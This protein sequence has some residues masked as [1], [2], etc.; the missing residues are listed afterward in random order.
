MPPQPVLVKGQSLRGEAGQQYTVT[1]KLGEGQFAE[2]WEVRQSGAGSDLRFAL[3]VEKVADRKSVVH[4]AKVLTKLPSK[5]DQAVKVIDTGYYGKNFFMVMELLGDSL[6]DVRKQ[7]AS[8]RVELPTVKAVGLSTLGAIEGLHVLGF[9]H[10][11]IKPANFVISPPN[12][13]AGRGKWVLIDFGLARKYVGEDGSHMPPRS[14]ASFRGSTTYASVHAHRNEDLSRRDDLWSW[15]YMLTELVEGCLLWRPDHGEADK[16]LV[17]AEKEKCLAQPELLAR[18]KLPDAL[19]QIHSHLK[20]LSFQ[21]TPDY[22]H[23]RACLQQLPDEQ[24]TLQLQHLIPQHV[25]HNGSLAAQ[26][27]AWDNSPLGQQ[28]P[29][30]PFID[31]GGLLMSPVDSQGAA[32]A[33]HKRPRVSSAGDQEAKRQRPEGGAARHSWSQQQQ[34]LSRPGSSSSPCDADDSRGDSRQGSQ[35]P[36]PGAAGRAQ[37]P[38]GSADAHKQ[39]QQQRVNGVTAEPLSASQQQQQ[40]LDASHPQSGGRASEISDLLVS[41][42]R[43]ASGDS[44]AATQ[45]AVAGLCALQPL[46]AVCAISMTLDRLV[47][48]SDVSAMPAVSQLL[49]DL[50]AFAASG[51]SEASKAAKQ[52]AAAGA[53]KAAARPGS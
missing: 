41:F 10:R 30:S 44:K 24:V 25:Q 19:L 20:G 8:G 2:V 27:Q 21:D 33:G 6:W 23:L 22:G 37:E 11:D 16:Q 51:A 49:L 39:Q 15:F 26:Q 29:A 36:H 5:C 32:A 42:D 1:R 12:A 40:Q 28:L 50:A 13:A 46:H 38:L 52:Q 4:E 35:G 7:C 18:S 34:R 31:A 9:I 47:R 45:Q 48:Q 14:D 3:K 17:L 53:A 43:E